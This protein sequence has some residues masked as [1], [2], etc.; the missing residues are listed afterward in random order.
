[1]NRI[2]KLR[3]GIKAG[4]QGIEVAPWHNPIAPKKDGFA[5][6]VVDIHSQETLQNNA[7]KRGFAPE[8][9]DGI[10][11]VD[12]QGDASNLHDL[13]RNGGYEGQVEWIVSSHNFEHL[14]NPL[15]FLRS[16]EALLNAGG[17]LTMAIPDKRFCF[18]RYQPAA[19]TAK[20]LEADLQSPQLHADTWAK[21]CQRTR[22]AGFRRPDGTDAMAWSVEENEPELLWAKDDVRTQF[23]ELKQHLEEGSNADF[24]GHR[25]YYTPA[26]FQLIILDLCEIGMLHLSVEKAWDT[27]GYEFI[28]QLI[29][30]ETE[31]MSENDYRAKRSELLRQ[32]EDE[33]AVVSAAYLKLQRE[34][35]V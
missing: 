22:R 26:V 32:A 20:I 1:M 19:T 6:L 3:D 29:C 25:W 16:C 4:C 11:S 18:D 28:V 8:R 10:E 13:L 17:T 9:I 30:K 5:T 7:R 27:Q 33:A 24:W 31:P 35:G 2:E 15:C 14:P 12:F 21:F 34:L 23:A